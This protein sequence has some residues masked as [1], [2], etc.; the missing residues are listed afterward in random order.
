M[1]VNDFLTD[2][3]ACGEAQYPVF[4]ERLREVEVECIV[5]HLVGVGYGDGIIAARES[6][7]PP[8]TNEA[9]ADAVVE[10]GATPASAPVG[11]EEPRVDEVRRLSLHGSCRLAGTLGKED[12]AAYECAVEGELEPAH[13]HERQVFAEVEFQAVGV[14][15]VGVL[16][17]IGEVGASGNGVCPLD[18]VAEMLVESGDRD[19][20]APVAAGVELVAEVGVVDMAGGEVDVALHIGGEVEVVIDRGGDLAELGAIDGHTIGGTQLVLVGDTIGDVCRGEDIG[21]AVVGGAGRVLTVAC[22]ADE[23]HIV[24]FVSQSGVDIHGSEGHIECEVA[25]EE[26][27]VAGVVVAPFDLLEE[28]ESVGGVVVGRHQLCGYVEVAEPCGEGVVGLVPVVVESACG[29]VACAVLAVEA[30]TQLGVEPRGVEGLRIVERKG[31]NMLVEVG[32]FARYVVGRGELQHACLE[33]IIDEVAA[34]V[35]LVAIGVGI[36]GVPAERDVVVEEEMT[37][38][39]LGG[40]G[41]AALVVVFRLLLLVVL[42]GDANTRGVA[43]AAELVED[44]FELEAVFAGAA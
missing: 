30:G 38:C 32:I 12:T 18:R 16:V 21:G 34:S 40:V 20:L 24:V 22:V 23:A 33:G 3:I 2:G 7:A 9:F 35:G 27:V 25:C 8:D 14:G 10:D 31:G 1:L 29:I 39:E 15:S 44:V 43:F 13:A 36:A 28:V 19:D 26:G 17:T 37:A 11:V 41:G 5:W 6:D 4:A 42:R